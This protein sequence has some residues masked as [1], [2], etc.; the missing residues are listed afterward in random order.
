MISSVSISEL[1]DV[2]PRHPADIE[3]DELVAFVGMAD[4]D[5]VAAVATDSELRPFGDVSKGYKPFMNGDVLMAKITPCFENCKIGQAQTSTDIAAGS[6]EFH[7][8]RPGDRLERRYLLHFLRQPWVLELGEL[9]MTGSGGQR[10]VPARF[11]AELKIPLPPIEEQRRIAAILDAADA[12]RAK[13][14]QALAKLD[15]LTQAIFIDMFG[16]P[17][18][19]ERNWETIRAGDLLSKIGSGATP[20]GGKSAYKEEGVTL[21]RSMNVHD[22]RFEIDGLAYIDEEQAERLS[23][24]VVE[25]DD[26][27]LNITGASVARV[28]IA[29]PWVLPARVN[30]HVAILRSDPSDADPQ[31]LAGQLLSPA[32]KRKLLSIAG[33]GATREAI[34]KGQIEDLQ[35]IMPP[36]E[37]QMKYSTAVSKIRN[38]RDNYLVSIGEADQLF[39]SLQQRAFRGDL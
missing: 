29:P 38:C 1:C 26:V 25:P 2:N 34:T 32:M 11:L 8:M 19:N 31:F 37:A 13:R 23:N 18:L 27:L 24:V 3:D 33:A 36:I 10:R 16:D 30:Q 12:L 21:I 6:T 7:V 22:D 35:L 15:T 39:A 17:V 5:D 9:R 14:R 20:K 4:L 28:C